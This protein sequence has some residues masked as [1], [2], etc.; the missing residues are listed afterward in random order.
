MILL[1]HSTIIIQIFIMRTFISTIET[2]RFNFA[3][4][5]N[6]TKD[7]LFFEKLQTHYDIFT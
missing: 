7:T 2:W 6:K 1:M 3:I 5:Y 4:T